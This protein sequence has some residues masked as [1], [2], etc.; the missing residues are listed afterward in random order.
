MLKAIVL[1]VLTF[2]NF[3]R[4]TTTAEFYSL[5]NTNRVYL[6]GNT[7]ERMHVRLNVNGPNNDK[8]LRM[9]KIC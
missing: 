1:T 4:S 2:F 6:V 8:R 5:R 7:G 9:I 3:I